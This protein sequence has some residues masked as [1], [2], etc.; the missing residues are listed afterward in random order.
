VGPERA[1]FEDV[2]ENYYMNSVWVYIC[3]LIQVLEKHLSPQ[4]MSFYF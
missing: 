2:W 4:M 1:I 3:V